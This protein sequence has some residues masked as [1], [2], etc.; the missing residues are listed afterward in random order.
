MER[1]PGTGQTA[2]PGFFKL[3]AFE[4]EEVSL[5]S[6]RTARASSESFAGLT[7]LPVSF[8]FEPRREFITLLGGAT[9][10]ASRRRP[11]EPHAPRAW[12]HAKRRPAPSTSPAPRDGA[13]QGQLSRYFWRRVQQQSLMY[14]L[15][16]HLKRSEQVLCL[17]RNFALA[18]RWPRNSQHSAHARSASSFTSS[19]ITQFVTSLPLSSVMIRRS[20]SM[21]TICA[22]LCS[23]V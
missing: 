1:T 21:L 17:H 13:C 12:P 4:P 15:G 10:A 23:A 16:R 2:V 19:A 8:H 18:I 11:C 9:A 7:S 5:N 20:P 3:L 14:P 6:F 22:G